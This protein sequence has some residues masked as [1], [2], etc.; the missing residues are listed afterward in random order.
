MERSIYQ[1]KLQ[2]AG[3]GRALLLRK[4]FKVLNDAQLDLGRKS[5]ERAL[6]GV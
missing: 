3:T 4:K 5:R 1:S 2:E 6:V